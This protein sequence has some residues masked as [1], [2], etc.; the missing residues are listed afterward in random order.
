MPEYGVYQERG[1]QRAYSQ[2]IS[3][4]VDDGKKLSFTLERPMNNWALQVY[5][6]DSMGEPQAAAVWSV[7]L[8]G[9]LDDDSPATV[10]THASGSDNDGD[11]VS[12]DGA[13]LL[14][15][16]IDVA[17]TLDLGSAAE[18]VVGVIGMVS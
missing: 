2:K 7:T 9:G 11:I 4:I 5:G 6:L 1:Y 16:E 17:D 8:K 12:I 18:L 14:Y 3:G 10:L 15:F 13:P